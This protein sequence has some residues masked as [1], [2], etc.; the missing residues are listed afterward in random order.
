[1]LLIVEDP[2]QRATRTQAQGEGVYGRMVEF[3]KR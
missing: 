2:D 3:E 1:M